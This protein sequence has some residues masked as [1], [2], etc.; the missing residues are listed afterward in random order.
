[1]RLTPAEITEIRQ[2]HILSQYNP[3]RV[4]T[5][6]TEMYVYEAH[7]RYFVKAW[8]GRSLKPAIYYGFT[9]VEARDKE[10]AHFI[11]QTTIQKKHREDAKT[12]RKT[13]D[14]MPH[15]LK[16]GDVLYTSLG[17]DQTNVDLYEVTKLI[18]S[19][20]VEVRQLQ[21]T[22]EE[23]GYMTGTTKPVLGQY[24]GE[25]ERY[26]VRGSRNTIKI[27]SYAMA[28]PWDGTPQRYS[29]YA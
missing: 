23:N 12:A 22:Y 2:A 25:A 3:V 20:M 8:L 6:V 10:V 16:V 28:T 15:T 18:G 14:A 21:Q 1:M 11:A 4:A 7:G 13:A 27:E 9:T 19:R 17:Y 26:R 29:S 24:R 5:D